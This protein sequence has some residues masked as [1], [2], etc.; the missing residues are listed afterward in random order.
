MDMAYWLLKTEPEEF[1]YDDLLRLGRDRWNGVTNNL[2]LKHMRAMQPGDLAFFYHTGKERAIVAVCQV[3]S[4]PYPDPA[5]GDPKLVV[6]DV[7]PGYRLATPV[8]L[9]QLKADPAFAGWELVRMGRLSVMPV[10]ADHW[11]RIHDM[12]G[13]KAV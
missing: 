7:A 1:S 2:A 13:T 8:T 11:H 5:Q 10:T 3:V 12:T 9:A 6:V 4:A